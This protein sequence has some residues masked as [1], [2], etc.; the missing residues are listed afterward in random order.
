VKFDVI[1][2]GDFRDPEAIAARGSSEL[3]PLDYLTEQRELPGFEQFV[4]ARRM[5][6]TQV[7]AGIPLPVVVEGLA[8]GNS[9]EPAASD[10]A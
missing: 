6:A 3:L 4:R 2:P 9:G 7:E 10:S 1:D 8:R 5:I